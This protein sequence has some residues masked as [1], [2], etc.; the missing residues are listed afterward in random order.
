MDTPSRSSSWRT[1]W[2][3]VEGD[4][5]SCRVA[6]EKSSSYAT[7]TN[8]FRSAYS[9]S[10]IIYPELKSYVRNSDILLAEKSGVGE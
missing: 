8:S 3:R 1:V 9:L 4:T 2:L 10:C 5:K 7:A 6:V